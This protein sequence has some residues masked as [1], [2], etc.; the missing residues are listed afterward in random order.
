MTE[1]ESKKRTT[2]GFSLQRDLIQYV[3]ELRDKDPLFRQRSRSAVL[4]YILDDF[5]RN[6]PVQPAGTADMKGQGA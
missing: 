3:D 2:T 5:R 6:H 4:N 1:A